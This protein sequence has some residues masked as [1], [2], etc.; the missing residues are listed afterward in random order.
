[1]KIAICGPEATG[2]T[3]LAEALAHKLGLAVLKDPRGSG[4][5][6]N[7]YHTAYEAAKVGP[8][9]RMLAEK[10]ATREAQFGRGVI[11]FSAIDAWVQ[12][13]RWGWHD[14]SPEQVEKLEERVTAAIGTYTHVVVMPDSQVAPFAGHRF[15]NA[16]HA[17]LIHRLTAG[18]LHDL[19]GPSVLWLTPGSQATYLDEACQFVVGKG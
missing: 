7:G 15:L 16:A 9:W 17:K 5:D 10:Q 12:L 8:F 19:K 14:M 2:K 13:M 4:G 6:F 3:G 11:D 18:Y 1:M